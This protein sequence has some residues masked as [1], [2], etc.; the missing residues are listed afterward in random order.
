MFQVSDLYFVFVIFESF[1]D[2]HIFQTET[3]RIKG[4]IL[5]KM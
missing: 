4:E 3:E 1:L 5:K 2:C